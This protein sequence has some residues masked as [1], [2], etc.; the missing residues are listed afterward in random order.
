[1]IKLPEN[2]SDKIFSLQFICGFDKGRQATLK[3]IVK[4]LEENEFPTKVITE[5]QGDL[6]LDTVRL[7]LIPK[8]ELNEIIKEK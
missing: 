1:M 3:A 5:W 2:P 8:N 4:W 7:F 6:D